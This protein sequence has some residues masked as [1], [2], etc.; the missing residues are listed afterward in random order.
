MP[1]NTINQLQFNQELRVTLTT[2]VSLYPRNNVMGIVVLDRHFKSNR[3]SQFF[4]LNQEVNRFGLQR[5][6]MFV[7]SKLFLIMVPLMTNLDRGGT[8]AE[9]FNDASLFFGQ[10]LLIQDNFVQAQWCKG[11][12]RFYLESRRYIKEKMSQAALPSLAAG[13][14]GVVVRPEAE[15]VATVVIVAC[16][17]VD[18]VLWFCG[19]ITC[20]P[21]I[22]SGI[23]SICVANVDVND[24]NVHKD[25]DDGAVTVTVSTASISV[26]TDI[27]SASSAFTPITCVSVTSSLPV[28]PPLCP[29]TVVFL[30]RLA[31]S[32][33]REA[34]IFSLSIETSFVIIAAAV[35]VAALTV[36]VVAAALFANLPHF[37]FDSYCFQQNA[38]SFGSIKGIIRNGFLYSVELYPS[39]NES[40]Y[41]R[42][43]MLLVVV[44]TSS[45]TSNNYTHIMRQRISKRLRNKYCTVWED[46][47]ANYTGDNRLD[48]QEPNSSF[49]ES[50]LEQS[51][52]DC[53]ILLVLV[54]R[55]GIVN[56]INL[57]DVVEV[58]DPV[59]LDA[60]V[61]IVLKDAERAEDTCGDHDVVVTAAALGVED[62]R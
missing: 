58:V 52:I 28:T 32:P 35:P 46:T 1:S 21:S 54:A 39:F 8:L 26:S 33:L 37:P 45:S 19:L 12:I 25:E 16:W 60:M 17:T 34:S 48:L 20:L 51:K 56:I 7:Q 13:I 3:S 38:I 55:F 36:V 9:I 31:S 10:K 47:V 53:F 6:Y 23:V 27:T 30:T 49:S 57:P 40:T 44:T 62:V 5:A 22:I 59:L 42:K 14:N 15:T 11:L 29:V 41:V 24:D 4:L 43:P 50:T 18:D 61:A 2:C